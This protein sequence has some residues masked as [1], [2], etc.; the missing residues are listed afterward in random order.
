MFPGMSLIRCLPPKAL[1]HVAKHFY[2]SRA[3]YLSQMQQECSSL[4]LQLPSW[5]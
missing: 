3:D 2:H 4:W 5:N 1:V